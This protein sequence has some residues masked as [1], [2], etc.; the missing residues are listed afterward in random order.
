M[1]PTTLSRQEE[2]HL[3]ALAER[4]KRARESI[5]V[6]TSESV[7]WRKLPLT[8]KQT[9]ILKEKGYATDKITRGQASEIIDR[10]IK[11]PRK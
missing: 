4:I 9:R 10:I 5:E 8:E 2:D 11:E 6:G 3:L 7:D 1:D